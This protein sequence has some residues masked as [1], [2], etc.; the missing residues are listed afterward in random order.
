ME[1]ITEIAGTW[2]DYAREIEEEMFRVGLKVEDTR[3]EVLAELNSVRVLL[4]NKT[5]KIVR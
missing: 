3:W 1:N 2:F 4:K 5:A